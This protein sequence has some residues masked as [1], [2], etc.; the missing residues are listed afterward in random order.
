MIWFGTTNLIE[1]LKWL[2]ARQIKIQ[3]FTSEF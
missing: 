1:W 3:E 2:N